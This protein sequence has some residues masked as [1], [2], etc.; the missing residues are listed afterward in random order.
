[1]TVPEIILVAGQGRCG[2]SLVMQMLSAAGV[3]CVGSY[4]D[5]EDAVVEHLLPAVPHSWTTACAGKAVKL[6]DPQRAHPPPG[7]RY[8]TIWLTRD[9]DQQARSQLKLVGQAPSRANRRAFVKSLRA[10]D[11]AAHCAL[12]DAGCHAGSNLAHLRFEQILADPITTAAALISYLG[13]HAPYAGKIQAMAGCVVP[14]SSD[15][16]EGFL[17]SALI[18]RRADA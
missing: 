14:R 8:K 4:P 5:F 15:C 10:G 11:N 13:L 18:E 2:T 6:L 3:P 16:L 17:E 1:V 9:V 12:R 7:P